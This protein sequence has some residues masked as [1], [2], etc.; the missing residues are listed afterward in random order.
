MKIVFL[1]AAEPL[2]KAY[3][4]GKNGIAKTPYPF[5]FEFTSHEVQ[6]RDLKQLEQLLKKH[7]ALGHCL[8]KGTLNRPLV[9]ESRAGTTNTID[10]TELLVLDLDGL[11]D[12]Y[13]AKGTVQV[14]A[15]VFLESLGLGDI[16][17]IIQW[18][19]SYGIE[20]KELRAHIFMLLDKPVAAPLLKQWLTQKNHEVPLLHD[21]MKLTK[22]GNAISWPLDISA[23]QNDKLIYIAPPVL[24]GIKDPLQGKPRI[25]LVRRKKSH[26]A[27]DQTSVTPSETL[28]AMTQKRV[29]KL[30][31][32]ANLPTRKFKFKHVGSHEV[33]AQP[34]EAAI[35]EI[36]QERG[37]VYFNLNG[38]DS[39]AYYHPEDKPEYIFNFKGEPTYL[40]KELLPDYWAQLTN[41]GASQRTGSDG[42]T[43]LAFCDRKTG[44]Y[45]RGTYDPTSD[46]LDINVARN[47]TQLRHFGKQYGVPIGDFIPE[48]DVI[49]DPQSLTRVDTQE[50]IVNRFQ[51]TPFM[52]NVGKAPKAMPPVARKI[53]QHALG[54]DQETFNHFVNWF[55]A[56]V[57]TRSKMRTAWVMHGVEGTGK[58]LLLNKILRPLFGEH[59]SSVGMFSMSEPYN[60]YAEKALFVFVDEVQTSTLRNEG[61]VLAKMR[62]NIAEP[63]IEI[64]RMYATPVEVRNYSNWI[65]ASNMPD[66]VK[67]KDDDRR[68]NIGKYQTA[69]LVITQSELDKLETELQA[70]YNYLI[71][72]P[73]DM[74]LAGQVLDSQER[75]DLIATGRSSVDVMAV[76]LLG[77]DFEFFVSQLPAGN[78]SKRN[79]LEISQTADYVSVLQTLIT[80]T[81]VKTGQCHIARDELFTLFDYCAGG[82]LPRKNKFTSLLRHHR[83]HMKKV[84]IDK[85]VQGVTTV[86]RDVKAFQTYANDYLNPPAPTAPAAAK[87]KAKP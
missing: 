78:Q 38:G 1:E 46:V 81:D 85:A 25:E 59:V 7:A 22:T 53:I 14:T 6:C 76:A 8:I 79:A 73:V 43:F 27:L 42:L 18:S 67:I 20:N 29:D 71:E 52:L 49:F 86:W 65:L 21:A 26:F 84:W 30:R 62:N 50:H 5:T 87:K 45:W 68:Y 57:Q 13:K 2:T 37:F 44:I 55:A 69:K 70:L 74:D 39:W 64:R 33:L 17:Y 10:A 48:W 36:K 72:Y 34:G 9:R 23:C 32:A 56:I 40:T 3:S 35:T 83:I 16:S 63:T 80:R 31:E 75:D 61:S 77:G 60:V 82:G 41:A 54:S 15:D 66:P 51:P 58:G 12:T 24:D 19:A 11:P 47:E 4:K 28:R